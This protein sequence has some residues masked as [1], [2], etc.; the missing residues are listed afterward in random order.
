MRGTYDYGIPVAISHSS[1][2]LRGAGGFSPQGADQPFAN[3]Y[4]G[5]FGNNYVDYRDEKRYREYGSFPGTEINEI[6]GRNFLKGTAEWNLPPL[7]FSRA[8]TPGLYASWIRPA[9]FAS[10]LATNLDEPGPAR[11]R[12]ASLGSQLDL[13]LTALSSVDLT[14]SVGVAVVLEPGRDSR[15]EIMASLT[16]LR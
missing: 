3:F 8:G 12:A 6:G 10:A 14:V 13:R 16:L 15:H 9:V 11:R 4:F 7:R 2:W 1:V 5:G